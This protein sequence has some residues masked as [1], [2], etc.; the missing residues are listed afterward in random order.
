M[1][2]WR[3]NTIAENYSILG[4]PSKTWQLFTKK[5]AMPNPSRHALMLWKV[6]SGNRHSNFYF[7]YGH[8]V[9]RSRPLPSNID[10]LSTHFTISYEILTLTNK[11]ILRI[12]RQC[13]KTV[14][15]DWRS[16]KRREYY[17]ILFCFLREVVQMSIK[18]KFPCCI[19]TSWTFL[20]SYYNSLRLFSN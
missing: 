10:S 12:K 6:I 9:H 15:S 17:I 3:Y 16:G 2:S 18:V 19:A 1:K 11:S 20:F 4:S 8:H 14:I 5:V 13:N 7:C